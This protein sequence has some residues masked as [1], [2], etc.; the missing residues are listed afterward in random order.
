MAMKEEAQ[1]VI[2]SWDMIPY[3]LN[4]KTKWQTKVYHSAEHT[5]LY[6][7][8]NGLSH[9]YP[10]VSKVGTQAAAV[11]SFIAIELLGVKH[12]IN[13]GTAGGFESRATK[14]G[15]VFLGEKSFYHDRRV[16]IND[17]WKAFASG[18]YELNCPKEWLSKYDLE[19]GIISTGNA[20]DYVEK[21]LELL[22]SFGGQ[23]KEM[24][25]A[26]IAELCEEAEIPLTVLK[27]ITDIVDGDRPTT[28]EF[29]ENLST[30][31]RELSSKLNDLLKGEFL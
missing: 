8:T 19:P 26:A 1:S 6:L 3:A 2:E 12:V 11:A 21:D 9:K 20:L 15:D 25:T 27:S 18:A 23:V 14:V 13:A 31:S 24:E 10:E 7:I 22:H 4:T 29:L 30:A 28:E 5:D 16:P 17:E